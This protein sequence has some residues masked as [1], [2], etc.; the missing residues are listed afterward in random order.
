MGRQPGLFRSNFKSLH[1]GHPKV[2][3]VI[4]SIQKLY[5]MYSDNKTGDSLFSIPL[6]KD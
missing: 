3:P 2:D 1:V 4:Q 6:S 5:T